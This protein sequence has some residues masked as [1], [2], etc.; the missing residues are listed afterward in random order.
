MKKDILIM[1]QYF[2][3]EYVSSAILPTQLAEDLAKRGLSVNVLCGYP[4]EYYYGSKVPIK[5]KYKGISIR[6]FKYTKLNNKNTIGR[7]INFFSLFMA[8]FFY[9]LRMLEY[10]CLLVYSNPPILPILPYLISKMSKIKFIFIAFDIYPDSALVLKAIK[11]KSLIK[12]LMNLI[13]KRVYKYAS[14]II[15]LSSEMK[16]YI[17]SNKKYV[18]KERI[19]VIEN[20]YTEEEIKENRLIANNEFR[21]LRKKWEFIILYTGNMGKA[22]DMETIINTVLELKN[23]KK[24][25][26]IFT[27]HG[28]KF[29][30][31]RDII[32]SNNIENA[33]LYGFLVGKDYLDILSIADICLVSLE[34]GMEGLAVPSKTYSYLAAS[35][36]V[37]AIMSNKTDIVKRLLKYKAGKNVLQGDVIELKTLLLKYNNIK[38]LKSEGENAK[39]IFNI[40]HRRE[41]CTSKYY[42]LIYNLINGY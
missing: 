24:M 1:C 22:Q 10:K 26:F 28:A 25:L 20:W 15:V 11:D 30:K 29:D 12:I 31:I 19:K 6:R 17:L 21:E 9:I 41:R 35:K 36:P 34:K 40:Y 7:V 39:K 32:Y 23:N 42:D 8:M 27:G 37:I 38:I 5:E 13:N 2:Y 3:P 4:T 14:Y 18:K 16:N 33:K